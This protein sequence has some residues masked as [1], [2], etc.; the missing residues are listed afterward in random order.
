MSSISTR[1]RPATTWLG[2]LRACLALGGPL[3]LTNA[4]EMSMNLISTVVIGHIGPE[5]LAASTLALAL[6]NAALLFGLGLTTAVSPLIARGSG[7]Q[8]TVR[9]AVQGG[10]WNAVIITGPIW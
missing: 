5:A 10:F 2:E 9:H 6:Y 1:S 3:V 8:A 7:D 4:I